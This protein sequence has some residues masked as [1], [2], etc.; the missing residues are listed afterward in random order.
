M[1][2]KY[3]ISKEV[4]N[5]LLLIIDE[6]NKNK[7]LHKYVSTL[8]YTLETLIVTELLV[9]ENLYFIKMYYAIYIQQENK[10]KQ[11]INR[12]KYELELLKKYSIEYNL[13]IEKLK[14]KYSK[15]DIEYINEDEK[16]FQAFKTLVLDKNINSFFTEQELEDYGFEGLIAHLEQTVLP[17]HIKKLEENELLTSNKAKQLSKEKWF[18]DYFG[19]RVQHTQVFKLLI[20]DRSWAKKAEDTKLAH[21]YN[22]NYDMTSSLLHFTS[23]SLFTSNEINTDEMNYNNEIINQYINQIVK[24]IGAVSKVMIYDIFDVVVKV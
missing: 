20:D 2:I 18:K 21:E 12:I 17:I 15:I 11:M 24:N 16:I 10:I 14:S 5:K 19:Q 3:H 22:L 9:N 4:T 13:E 23:Y 8:R 1:S 7:D 6:L